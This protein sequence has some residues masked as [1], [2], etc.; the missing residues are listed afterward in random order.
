[1]FF[2]FLEEEDISFGRTIRV[3]EV[4]RIH[5]YVLLDTSGSI[6]KKDFNLSREA[7]IALISK[8]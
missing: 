2:P 6:K 3:G 7:T 4:S 1:M 8:V 5:I